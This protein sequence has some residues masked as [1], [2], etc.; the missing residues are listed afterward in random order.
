MLQEKQTAQQC[1]AKAA[2]IKTVQRYCTEIAK[3]VKLDFIRL[4]AW[5]LIA[6]GK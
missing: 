5:W 4:V 6:W 1:N 2:Y 3:R